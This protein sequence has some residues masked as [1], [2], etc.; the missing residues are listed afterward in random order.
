MGAVKKEELAAFEKDFMEWI[1]GGKYRIFRGELST[2]LAMGAVKKEELA[3]FEKDFMEW[4]SGGKYRI[5][6][7]ELSTQL[8]MGAVKKDQGRKLTAID[9]VSNGNDIWV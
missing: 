5:F 6:R 9:A 2:Q 8:G 1:S 7:G 3:A 4:I